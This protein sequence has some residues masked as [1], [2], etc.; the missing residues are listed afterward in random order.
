M[1]RN[2][3]LVFNATKPG[4][5][6]LAADLAALARKHG[7]SI[8]LT[9]S[10]PIPD[11]FLAGRDACLVIGG[12]GTLLGVAAKA[13]LAGVPV[14]GVNRGHLGF[15]TPLSAG[16]ARATL[17]EILDGAYR[18]APR[19]LLRVTT[20]DRSELALNEVHIKDEDHSRVLRLEVAANGQLVT[21][22]FSDGLI[23]ATPTG[24]TAYNLSAGGPIVHPEV[25]VI[26]MTPICPHTLS[27]RSIIFPKDTALEIRNLN[28]DARPLVTIDGRL[29]L[30]VPATSPLSITNASEQL[31]FLQP[32]TY[33]HYDTLR[34]KLHWHGAL[35]KT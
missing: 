1:L 2:L 27:N 11:N 18:V 28:P 6:Q 16:E 32:A 33:S 8:A 29:S 35:P 20:P 21:D 19:S 23:F 4:A 9:D 22:Y 14:L 13:A 26:T 30:S 7:A 10:H 34:R 17:P 24:S 31:L 25:R 15:L 3:A 5:P 12:D